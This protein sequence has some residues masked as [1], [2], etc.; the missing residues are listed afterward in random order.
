MPCFSLCTHHRKA[1]DGSK[2]NK[3]LQFILL[4]RSL[5]LEGWPKQAA[6]SSDSEMEMKKACGSFP[7]PTKHKQYVIVKEQNVRKGRILPS[8][9]SHNNLPL[10]KT[11]WLKGISMS[12]WF[13][14][15]VEWIS[16]RDPLPSVAP[17]NHLHFVL[18]G[19]VHLLQNQQCSIFNMVSGF[20]LSLFYI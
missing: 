10:V 6:W 2:Y 15:L 3:N 4:W 13:A 19:P 1:M 11:W 14:V 16:R 9:C 12:H 17:G 20:D 7:A 8:Y 5:V 18:H